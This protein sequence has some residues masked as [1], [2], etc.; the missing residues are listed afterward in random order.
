[1]VWFCFCGGCINKKVRVVEP[2]YKFE[3]FF[4][5]FIVIIELVK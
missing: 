3:Q 4:F 1:M 2:E 5:I